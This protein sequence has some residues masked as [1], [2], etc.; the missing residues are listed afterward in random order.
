MA[1]TPNAPHAFQTHYRA[2]DSRTRGTRYGIRSSA[3]S[4]RVFPARRPHA[5]LRHGEARRRSGHACGGH[6]RPR[7]H[8]RRAAAVRDVREGGSRDGQARQAHLRLRGVLHH[9]RGAAQ[10]HEAQALPPAS[11]GQDE[12]GLPQP[13]EAGQRIARRQ[14]LLQAAHHVQHAAEVRP[15]HH[16][17]V[18]MHRGHHPEAARQRPVRRRGRVGQEVRRL[19]RAGRLLHRAAEPGHPHGRRLHA[20]RAQPHAHGRGPAP[21]ASRPS[22]RTTSTTSRARTRRRRTTCCASARARP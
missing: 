2:H 20:D 14:L 3:Q 7:R 18:G 4:H 22:P 13:G 16:R 8:V 15:R 11:A 9:R 19:L 1:T 6:H 21:P 10:G 12:R 17:L 5:H